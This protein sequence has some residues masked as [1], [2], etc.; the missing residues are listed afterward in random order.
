MEETSEQ[1]AVEALSVGS[2]E[3]AQAALHR[4][5]NVAEASFERRAQLQHALDSR[6]VIEQAKGVLIERYGLPPDAAFELLRR[7]ARRSRTKIHDLA[8]EVVATRTSPPPIEEALR[9][10]A[11]PRS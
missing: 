7:A 8:R 5:L 3:D 1:R 10:A 4:L 11:P 9:V 6:I 2:V